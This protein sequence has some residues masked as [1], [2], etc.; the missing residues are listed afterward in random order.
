MH[1]DHFYINFFNIGITIQI[2]CF[3]GLW[4]FLFFVGF[5]YLT[6]QWGKADDPPNGYGVNNVQAAIVFSLFSVVTWVI[7]LLVNVI[8]ILD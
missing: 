6:N 1:F 8:K 2:N 4:A 3:T 7:Y 5:C